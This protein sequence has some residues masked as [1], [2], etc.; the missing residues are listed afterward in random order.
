[1]AQP[2]NLAVRDWK[3][4][5]SAGHAEEAAQMREMRDL[6]VEAIG[7]DAAE[8]EIPAEPRELPLYAPLAAV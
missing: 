4:R 2:L 5:P 8:E 7:Q 3:R 1:M 6:V